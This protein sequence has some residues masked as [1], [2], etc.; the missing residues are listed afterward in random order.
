MLE[1][2]EN[3]QTP[4][5]SDTDLARAQRDEIVPWRVPIV[6]DQHVAVFEDQYPVTPGHRLFVPKWNTDYGVWYAFRD[7]REHGETLRRSGEIDGYNI[8]LNQ[9]VAAGQTVLYPHV[10][11]IPRMSMDCADPTG[12]VRGVIPGQANYRAATYQKP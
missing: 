4:P 12:G 7:A 3:S 5:A 8:G 10:H 1:T 6:E 11:F 9:G 2:Q